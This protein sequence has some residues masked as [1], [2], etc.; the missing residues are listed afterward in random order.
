MWFPSVVHNYSEII[1]H[2]IMVVAVFVSEI[3]E[4]LHN[5]HIVILSTSH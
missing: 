1:W 4:R 2:V 5:K 3:N